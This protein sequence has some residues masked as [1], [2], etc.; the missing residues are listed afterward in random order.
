[1][2]IGLKTGRCVSIFFS[3]RRGRISG[4]VE[5]GIMAALL[6]S[7]YDYQRL[8]LLLRQHREALSQD[9]LALSTLE[10]KLGRAV[11]VPPEQIPPDVVTLYSTATVTDLTTRKQTRF[12]L[13]FPKE[14]AKG[15]DR[16]SVL[17]PV[18]IA[19]LG[20]RIGDT[21]EC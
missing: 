11:I 12:T 20:E 4:H 14:A 21:I 19:L 18:G 6:M 1:Y 9:R 3:S 16:I 15:G 2:K 8:S 13:V 7:A 10:D 17:A 5:G